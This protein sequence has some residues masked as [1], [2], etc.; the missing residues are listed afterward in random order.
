MY[1]WTQLPPMATGRSG[2]TATLVQAA[3]GAA[4]DVGTTRGRPLLVVFGGV[5]DRTQLQDDLWVR[6]HTYGKAVAL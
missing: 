4:A 3:V 6:T 5:V 1:R 2:H